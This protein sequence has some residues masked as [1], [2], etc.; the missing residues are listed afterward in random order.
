[1]GTRD[2]NRLLLTQDPI[3]LAGGV[4]LYEYAGSNPVSFDDP[5]GLSPSCKGLLHC[6]KQLANMEWRGFVGGSDPTGLTPLREDMGR[7][8]YALGKLSMAVAGAGSVRLGGG[9]TGGAGSLADDAVVVRGGTKPLP[10]PGETFS[11]A[12]G[13]TLDEAASGVPH[14]TIRATTVGQ[15]R[16]AGGTVTPAPELTRSG[17]MNERHVNVCLGWGKC[18]FGQ[19]MPNPVPG[20]ERIK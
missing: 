20:A 11:A 13:R 3:G 7:F 6:A 4:N 18:P 10:A 2:R 9:V 8:G 17:V 1:V 15:I 19:P 16:S 12:A 14:G 5:L